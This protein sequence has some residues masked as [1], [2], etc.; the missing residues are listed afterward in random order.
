MM[1]E[2]EMGQIKSGNYADC[3]LVN[4][5]PLEE[6]EVLQDHDKLNIIV[7]NGRVHKAGR[8]EYLPQPLVPDLKDASEL[9][10]ID[11]AIAG[12]DVNEKK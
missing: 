9:S 2:D 10:K 3:I 5:N 12:M 11:S 8:K 6:I 4:G 1:R 7:I